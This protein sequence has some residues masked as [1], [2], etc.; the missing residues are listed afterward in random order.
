MCIW[1]GEILDDDQVPASNYPW[2]SWVNIVSILSKLEL[3]FD[4]FDPKGF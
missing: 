1:K 4:L 3:G 2:F